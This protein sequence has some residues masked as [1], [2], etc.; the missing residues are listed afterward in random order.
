[1][2]SGACYPDKAERVDRLCEVLSDSL[3]REVIHYFENYTQSH[4][5][6]LDEVEE[7]IERRLPPELSAGLRSKL[8]HC[9]LPKLED[10]GWLT[11]DR[12]TG[13]VHYRGHDSADVLLGELLGVFN[14]NSPV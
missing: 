1:M 11:F 5:A 9:H 10:R 7:H 13:T 8:L 4:V 3:R 12:H 14:E 2:S 6:R